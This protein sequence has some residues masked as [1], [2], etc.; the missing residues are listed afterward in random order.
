MARL[1]GASIL[2]VLVAG[3]PLTGQIPVSEY[4]ARR[5]TVAALIGDG[6][7]LVLGAAGAA[8]NRSRVE[9]RSTMSRPS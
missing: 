9:G 7:L 2:A 1:T 6:V 3:G 5:D 8:R 4:A